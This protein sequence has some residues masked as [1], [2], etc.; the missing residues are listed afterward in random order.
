MYKKVTIKIGDGVH[1]SWDKQT[2]R[3]IRYSEP[4]IS[5]TFSTKQ[6]F[7]CCFYIKNLLKT[8]NKGVFVVILLF[9]ILLL[10]DVV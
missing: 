3:N 6:L 2:P 7:V 5:E 1:I 4:Y 10:Y 8:M 9:I